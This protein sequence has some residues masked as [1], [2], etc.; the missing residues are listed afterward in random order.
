LEIFALDVHAAIHERRT[1]HNY[2]PDAIAEGILE[3]SLEAAHQAPCHK[4][5]YPWR[6]VVV[7]PR[8]REEI[9]NIAVA[10]KSVDKPLSSEKVS[11]VQGKILNPAALVVVTQACCDDDFRSR[12]D[13]AACA[14]AIQNMALSLTADGVGS[15]WSTG[16]LTRDRG[17]YDVLGIDIALE[18]II[19][20]IWVGIAEETPQVK[21]PELSSLVREI[22]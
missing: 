5:T 22:P 16:G 6:F 12:E 3:R 9:A 19:G 8:T 13:Y 20:F 4:R 2:R 1:I 11:A 21:R 15:K 10:L 14:C 18:E 7:G 17:I